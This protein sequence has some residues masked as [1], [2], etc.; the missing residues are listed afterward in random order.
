MDFIVCLFWVR[1]YNSASGRL[2]YRLCEVLILPIDSTHAPMALA[3]NQI[4]V[5]GVDCSG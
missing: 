3:G 5:V 4:E 2:N 1:R